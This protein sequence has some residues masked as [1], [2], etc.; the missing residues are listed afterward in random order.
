MG[1]VRQV[2]VADLLEATA[3]EGIKRWQAFTEPGFWAGVAEGEQEFE[4]G[5]HHHTDNHT[6]VYVLDGRMRI[7]WG[8]EPGMSVEGTAGDFLH[9]PPHTIHREVNPDQKPVRAAVIR[10][11]NGEPVVNVDG[12]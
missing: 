9:V 11:G 8:L 2:G 7:E 3:T 10:I 4:S 6:V 5:W 12:P 1:T